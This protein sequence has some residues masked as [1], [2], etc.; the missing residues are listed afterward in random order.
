MRTNK[1]SQWRFVKLARKLE[2]SFSPHL[3]H[4]QWLFAGETSSFGEQS[5]NNPY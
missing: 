3:L 2:T 1:L 4:A 5:C